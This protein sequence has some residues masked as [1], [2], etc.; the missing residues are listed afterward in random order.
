MGGTEDCVVGTIAE[1][2]CEIG[3]HR[4]VFDFRHL[5]VFLVSNKLF[6]LIKSIYCRILLKKV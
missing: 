2:Y 1:E 5:F 4:A 3:A 6:Y